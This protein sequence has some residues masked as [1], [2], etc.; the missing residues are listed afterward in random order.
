MDRPGGR[1]WERA[2]DPSLE[3]V[4]LLAG[5]HDH[6]GKDLRKPVRQG[7]WKRAGVR[8]DCRS[9]TTQP[10]VRP[11]DGSADGE[12]LDR[13][14][15]G[16]E[17]AVFGD[18]GGFFFSERSDGDLDDVDPYYAIVDCGELIV[19]IQGGPGAEPAAGG[20][21]GGRVVDGDMAV[22]VTRGRTPVFVVGAADAGLENDPAGPFTTVGGR[23]PATPVPGP[24]LPLPATRLRIHLGTAGGESMH[25]ADLLGRA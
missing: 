20:P 1:N 10:L 9:V 6:F 14:G 3:S 11:A 15:I 7:S 25:K 18:S 4:R 19:A 24:A 16:T 22:E 23:P 12:L 2:S 8:G 13:A 17:V 21:P 5:N